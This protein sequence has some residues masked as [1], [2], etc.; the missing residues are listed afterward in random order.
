MCPTGRGR[1]YNKEWIDALEL[2]NIT[3]LLEAAARSALKR[4]ESRGVHY[5]EDYPDTDNDN[6]L[7]ES[8]V[9]IKDGEFTITYRPATATVISPPKGV[10][11]Y[12]D[13]LKQMMA[14]HSDIG[15]SH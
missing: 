14:A 15:G 8:I 5:R 6:W 7:K 2:E 4:T 12:L 9:S 1:V 13:M 3:M 10:T 11:P